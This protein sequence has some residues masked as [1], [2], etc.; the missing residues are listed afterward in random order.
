MKKQTNV[1]KNNS[2]KIIRLGVCVCF[3]CMCVSV[4]C[5]GVLSKVPRLG[6]LPENQ[7]SLWS[8]VTQCAHVVTRL[9]N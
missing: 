7:G 2:Q 6:P 3:V 5:G 4:C 1:K 9:G 8:A